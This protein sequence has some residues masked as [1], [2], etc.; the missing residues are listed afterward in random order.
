MST[1]LFQHHAAQRQQYSGLFLAP[2]T[3][4]GTNK[5]LPKISHLPV[6]PRTFFQRITFHRFE[7]LTIPSRGFRGSY[8]PGLKHLVAVTQINRIAC[9]LLA[10][11]AEID[12]NSCSRNPPPNAKLMRCI[13]LHVDTSH[14]ISPFK[15][16]KVICVTKSFAKQWGRMFAVSTASKLID[17]V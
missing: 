12:E 5:N 8:F 17:H 2:S 6:A 14:T 1:D 16:I 11:A 10:V 7:M 15:R 9:L 3:L 4:R 13:Y